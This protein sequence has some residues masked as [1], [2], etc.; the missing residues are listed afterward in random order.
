MPK[1]GRRKRRE[2]YWRARRFCGEAS[3]A[4]PQDA[5]HGLATDDEVL[6]GVQFFAEMRIVEAL[7][8]AARQ[9]EDG[10]AQGSGESPGHGPSAIAVMHPSHG[11]GAVA[12]LEPLH[13]PFTQLQQTRGFAYAQPPARPHSQSL[14]PVGTLSDS[15]SPSL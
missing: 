3:L 1:R 9:L 14:S 13:L 8:L 15:L 7:I 12:P 10:S 11:V 6:L 2:R 5:A 4:R